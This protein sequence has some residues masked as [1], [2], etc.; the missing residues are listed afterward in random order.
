[1]T[2]AL[3]G[4]FFDAFQ[5][6]LPHDSGWE[7]FMLSLA[8]QYPERVDEMVS[9]LAA[10]DFS[11]ER[12]RTV[13]AT[14]CR[15]HAEGMV[16]NVYT[17]GERLFRAGM[18]ESGGGPGFLTDLQ[19]PPVPNVPDIRRYTGILRDYSVRRRTT[20]LA[21]RLMLEATERECDTPAMLASGAE[22]L[23]ALAA[24]L[25][26]ESSFRTI[27]DSLAAQ[28][29]LNAYATSGQSADAIGCHIAGL[30][31]M[32]PAGGFRPGDMIVLAALTSRGKTAWALNTA[33]AAA[34]GGKSVAYVS[35]EMDEASLFDRLICQAAELDLYA[36]R[37][38]R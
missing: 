17:V 33:L 37:R 10:D 12:H 14:V 35:M 2:A 9:L 1:M 4:L 11:S 18:L 20:Y 28:G 13:W 36:L 26:P 30:N 7:Q 8:F 5:R 23:T 16:P 25:N 29:G 22:A 3:P 34:H 38:P 15:L 32:I 27:E 6:G 31:Q 21:N 24:D 19:T